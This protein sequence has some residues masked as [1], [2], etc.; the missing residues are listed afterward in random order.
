MSEDNRNATSIA[1]IGMAGRFPGAKNIDELWQL[2][3]AGRNVTSR[4]PDEELAAAGVSPALINHPNYVKAC[5]KL[6]GYDQFDAGFFG[7]SPRQATSLDPQGRLFLEC[8]WEALEHAAYDP[9]KYGGV[10]GMFGA[11]GTNH[12]HQRYLHEIV[13]SNGG[14][15]HQTSLD[16]EK[17]FLPMRVSYK[18][19]LKGPS[20]AVQSACSSSLVAVH[21]ACQSILTFE[22]DIALAGGVSIKLNQNSGYLYKEGGISAA[23]G[24]CRPYDAGASGTIGGSGC[25]IV[26][27]KLLENALRDGDEIHGVIRSTS[28][29]NDGSDKAGFSAPGIKSQARLIASALAFAELNPMDIGMLEGHGTG[30]VL[31]DAVELTALREAFEISAANQQAWCAL[32]SIKSNIGHLDTAAGVA[33]LIKAVLCLKHKHFVPSLNFSKPNPALDSGNNPFTV[34]TEYKPWHSDGKPRRAGVSSF[35]M[36]GTNAHAIIEEAPT[37]PTRPPAAPIPRVFPLSAHKK[38]TLQQLKV[39]LAKHLEVQPDLDVGDLA[40]TLQTGRRR[41]A[42]RHAVVAASSAELISA[43]RQDKATQ[44][45]SVDTLDQHSDRPVVFMIPGQ[46]SQRSGAIKALYDSEQYFRSCVDE[47]ANLFQAELGFDIRPFICSSE[48]SNQEL[49]INSTLV[50]QPSV[51]TVGYGLSRLWMHWG[52]TPA[53]LIGHSV[54]EYVAA[55]IAGVLSLQDCIKLLSARASMVNA[56]PMGAMLVVRLPANE[57]RPFLGESLSIA[58]I[59]SPTQC[60]VSGSLEDVDAL[61]NSLTDRAIDHR[62]LPVSHG[63][64]S[65]MM[66]PAMAALERVARECQFGAPRLPYVSC[67]TGKLAVESETSDPNFWARHLREPVNFRAALAVAVP[68]GSAIFLEV[69]TGQALCGLARQQFESSA[70]YAYL[71]SLADGGRSDRSEMLTQLATLWSLGANINWSALHQHSRPRRVGLTPYPFHRQR[72]WIESTKPEAMPL[73]VEPCFTRLEGRPTEGSATAENAPADIGEWTD[74]ESTI[75]DFWKEVLGVETIGRSDSFVALGGDSLIAQRVIARI[76]E[77]FDVK[78]SPRVL[79]SSFGTIEAV[80]RELVAQLASDVY[81]SDTSGYTEAMDSV[82]N[83]QDRA[84]VLAN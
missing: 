23:D 5:N 59:N 55:C 16:G 82:T 66:E 37:G 41:F 70:E 71:G 42:Y 72:Y 26:V 19:G 64:H 50:T 10:I 52:V 79:I 53:A 43:L 7:Y 2:L 13:E 73:N 47:C 51:F 54:G 11:C 18:L 3:K 83:N 46:G 32:G 28:V 48:N 45:S 24:V 60:V 49:S 58:S 56:L 15:W 12:Y 69:G 35:G 25:G 20:V 27:L 17:D 33:G 78:I 36:G 4:L 31:G 74:L 63:F 76:Y 14:D 68:G 9:A 75:V 77:A 67:L 34:S 61:S 8:A 81:E 1:I 30:T 6:D 38:E 29:N 22:S 57:C 21:L 80:T 40:Y 84:A 39:E 65:K 62:R 44:S